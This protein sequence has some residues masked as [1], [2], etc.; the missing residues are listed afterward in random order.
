MSSSKLIPQ[1]YIQCFCLLIFYFIQYSMIAFPSDTLKNDTL[2]FP[3]SRF[4]NAENIRT[5]C[6]VWLAQG[7]EK[8]NILFIHGFSG[9]TFSWRKNATALAEEGYNVI[10]LDLPPFGFSEKPSKHNY[11]VSANAVL[12]W[13]VLE[14][15]FPDKK[16]WIFA[17]HSMGANTAFAA[18]A[19]HPERV[20]AL[21]CIDGGG[22]MTRNPKWFSRVLLKNPITFYT[23]ELAGRLYFFK[24]K[25]IEKLLLSAY[26]QPPDKDAVEG[27]LR[28]LNQKGTAGRIMYASASREIFVPTDKDLPSKL[29]FIW[30]EKDQWIPVKSGYAL[31]ERYPQSELLIIKDAGHCP[32]E[33]HPNEVNDKIR[34]FLKN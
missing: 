13:K 16:E 21:I 9:S 33:T 25:K 10:A 19:L 11:S 34:E 3:E 27:Y 24:Y 26:G 31:H 18:N 28:G 23:A 30:G 4:I 2:P 8:G 17:G 12:I 6:R 1:G 5:H 29:L 15:L 20:K 7:E 22:I 32:M 14:I